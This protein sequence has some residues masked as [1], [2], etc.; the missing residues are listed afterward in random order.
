MIDTINSH[1]FDFQ[2]TQDA[3][4]R[5]AFGWESLGFESKNFTTNSGS[6][7]FVAVFFVI[8]QILL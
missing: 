2:F 1:L 4:I 3:N 7:L 8:W 5:S 6:L